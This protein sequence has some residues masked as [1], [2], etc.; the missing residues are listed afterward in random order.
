MSAIKMSVKE[1]EI[2]NSK[3]TI[4]RALPTKQKRMGRLV[5]LKS[6]KLAGAQNFEHI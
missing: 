1:R 2:E 6:L 3:E 5:N 4:R